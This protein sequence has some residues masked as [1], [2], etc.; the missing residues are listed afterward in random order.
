MSIEL[1]LIAIV[2][3]ILGGL[4]GSYI[5]CWLFNKFM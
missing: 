5:S 4:V 3:G 1:L 2:F